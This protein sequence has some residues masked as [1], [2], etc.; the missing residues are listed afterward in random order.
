MEMDSNLLEGIKQEDK[1]IIEYDDRIPKIK[2]IIAIGVVYN[3]LLYSLFIANTK[4]VFYNMYA[5]FMMNTLLFGILGIILAS[6]IAFLLNK[7]IPYKNRL[8]RVFWIII[9]CL[10]LL[11]AFGCTINSLMILVGWEGRRI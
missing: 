7:K 5:M 10:T 8:K 6:P 3:T 1:E 2:L 4:S 11:T 9:L